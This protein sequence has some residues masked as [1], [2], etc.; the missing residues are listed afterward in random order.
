MTIRD[1]CNFMATCRLAVLGTMGPQNRPQSSLVGIAVTQNAEIIFDTLKDSRK[2]GNLLVRPDCSF[3]MGWSGE[4]TVQFEGTAAELTG[5]DL[6]VYQELYF[7]VWPECRAHLSWPGITYFV[8]RPH[9]IRYS[10]FDQKPS[11][12]REF[13]NFGTEASR[14]QNLVSRTE[15]DK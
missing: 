2:Y 12:I 15:R 9:W 13:S 11:L 10:D 8:V 7:A 1:V 6:Q 5:S 4:Q 14:N 3:A